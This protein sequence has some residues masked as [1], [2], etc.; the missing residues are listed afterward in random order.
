MVLSD[1]L[2]LLKL[3]FSNIY[4]NILHFYK[5]QLNDMLYQYNNILHRKNR[6]QCL[7]IYSGRDN[8]LEVMGN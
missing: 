3:H 8:S 5:Q 4:Q 2:F 7:E 1:A 6:L